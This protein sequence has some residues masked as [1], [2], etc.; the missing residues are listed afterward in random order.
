[1]KTIERKNNKVLSMV[2]AAVLGITVFCIPAASFATDGDEAGVGKQVTENTAES[3]R[4]HNGELIVDTEN[5]ESSEGR[6]TSKGA[7]HEAW[8]ESNGKFYSSNGKVIEGAIRKGIDVSAWQDVIDWEKVKA[9]G[10]SFAIIRCGYGKNITKYDD[11]KWER[12]VSEC[13]RLGIPYGVY[14]YSHA[15]S[16][17]YADSEAEHVLRLL[18]GHTP[19]YPVYYD[20]EDDDVKSAGRTT[21]I[22]IAKRFCSKIENSG[23]TAGIYAN[24]NW[25]KKYLN[26]SS[27]DKYEKWVAQWSSTCDYDKE[28]RLWQC[29]SKGKVSGIDGNVDL[30]FEFDLGDGFDPNQT[31]SQSPTAI[32]GWEKNSNGQYVLVR[33]NGQI[34]KSKWVTINGKKYYAD[35]NGVRTTGY[36]KIDSYYYL[37]D[38]NG[39]MKTGD[40]IYKSKQYELGSNGKSTRYNVKTDKYLNYRTGPST[41][42]KIKG[43]YEKSKTVSII[44]TS[45]G[46]GQMRNGYWIKLSYTSKIMNYPVAVP[47]KVKTKS[48]LNGRSGPST[49]YAVKHTYK[50]GTTLKI[51]RV[52]N[53][54][55]KTESGCWVLLRHTKRK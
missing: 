50:K 36:K 24:L 39:V 28:Y 34:V 53:G 5:Q 1:M 22:K 9:S 42:Y 31:Q 46:W 6:M 44:R 21:I 16:L 15:G 48:A 37:F 47:Y 7:S 10:I 32:K 51:V 17:D 54:W 19:A 3:W 26:D 4:Y 45:D 41:K 23:Y 29:T 49:S 13:E 25:W 33:N 27:L 35:S 11:S 40:V 43:T 2:I 38:S 30:N 55:G 14:I 52:K 12:N 18:E 8:S 20:L